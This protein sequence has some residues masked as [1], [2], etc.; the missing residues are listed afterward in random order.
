MATCNVLKPFQ[1]QPDDMSRFRV[2]IFSDDN[3]KFLN[4]IN[5]SVG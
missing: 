5:W 4:E 2:A 1:N 3:D